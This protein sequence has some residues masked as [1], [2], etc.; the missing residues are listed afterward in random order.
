MAKK[1]RDFW[2]D[3]DEEVEV[4]ND[5]QPQADVYEDDQDDRF[6]INRSLPFKIITRLLLFVMA[7][8]VGVSG[9][10]CYRYIDDRYDGGFTN[11]YFSSKGFSTEYNEAVLKVLKI[12][13][14]AEQD[15][16]LVESQEKIDAL[17]EGI[18]DQSGNF[19]FLVQDETKTTLYASS[20]DA[21]DRI[22]ASNHFLRI[23]S[24][25]NDFIVDL[26]GVPTKGLNKEAWKTEM[27]KLQGM[28]IIY[29]SVD[30]NLSQ[31]GTFYDSYMNYQML[32]KYFNIG[33][34]VLIVAVVLF[35]V[36]L[37]VC[38]ASTGRENGYHGIKLTLYDRVYTEFA[39]I[40]SIGV[41]G[42]V[43]YGLWYI[44]KYG[45][46]EKFD[47]YISIAGA[48]L[49]Y[50]IVIRSYFSLVRRIKSGKFVE[51]SLIY[52]VG[53]WINKGLNHLPKAVKGIII[54]LFLV[55]LNGA[56][57]YALLY[58]REYAVHDI[59]IV[60]IAVPV[61]FIIELIVFICCLFGGAPEETYDDRPESADDY[62]EEALPEE[63]HVN[64][65]DWSN[66]DFGKAVKDV[67][68]APYAEEAVQADMA[69]TQQN[70]V[71]P[72]AAKTVILS[73]EEMEELKH[74]SAPAAT[75]DQEVLMP[76]VDVSGV[77]ANVGAT[78]FIDVSA[79]NAAIEQDETLL[80]F[81]EL[82]KDVRKMYR[83]KL[84]N[85]NLGVTLRA[86]EKPIILDIDKSNA[87]KVLS[88]LFDNVI[89]YAQEGSRV[90]I[91]M[92]TQKGKMVYMMKNTIKDE[93]IGEVTSEMGDSLKTAKKIIQAEGGKFITTIDNNVFKA[94]ILLSAENA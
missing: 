65:D 38:V 54:F 42:A 33:R 19:S 43:I 73:E 85:R 25:D 49:L 51:N 32:T 48:V 12:V 24:V 8:A 53:H 28:Y 2:D 71:I 17:V 91:E 21:K 60:F 94:G 7:V 50:I 79:V 69:A 72:K 4:S 75:G 58:L 92:Y 20:S 1:K 78:E 57:V 86:P 30:N 68:E 47:T 88:I 63:D 36:L 35:I 84:K 70:V 5:R 55:A 27:S 14:A 67:V 61:I 80:D 87:I 59:P 16:T 6:H 83:A 64:P 29:T 10:I 76:K 37:V 9:Y 3:V 22:E 45:L 23:N 15:P 56:L 18:L 11:N 39:A 90:Y 26:G 82:N 34:F 81:I 40:I 66:V 46:I 31:S 13:E 44:H 93:L 52:R 62:P 41:L 89:R 77:D 74:H